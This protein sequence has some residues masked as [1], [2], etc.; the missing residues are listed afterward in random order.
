MS[1]SIDQLKAALIN[2]DAAGD[3]QSAQILADQIAAQQADTYV[4][5]VPKNTYLKDAATG[6]NSGIAEVVDKLADP[7]KSFGAWAGGL[8][9]LGDGT[10]LPNQTENYYP[11]PQTEVGKVAEYVPEV[12]LSVL[13]WEAGASALP[14]MAADTTLGWVG[15]KLAQGAAG[16]VGAS[17]TNLQMPTFE[18]TAEDAL[19]NVALSAVFHIPDAWS[20]AKALINKNQ[21]DVVKAADILGVSPSMGTATGNKAVAT[22]ENLVANLP[23]GAAAIDM[24]RTTERE[25]LNAAVDGIKSDLGFTGSS[26]ELGDE[27]QQGV[28]QYISDFKSES[29]ELYDKLFKA[30][31]SRDKIATPEFGKALQEIADKFKDEPLMAARLDNKFIKDLA[32]AYGEA[33]KIV[34]D[35]EKQDILYS[36]TGNTQNGAISVHSA[37]ALRQTIYDAITDKVSALKDVSSGEL[38]RLYGALTEDLNSHMAQ[39]GGDALKLW[40]EA[41]SHY[42]LGA[43]AIKES[44]G[45]IDAAKTGDAVYTQLFGDASGAMRVPPKQKIASLMQVLPEETQRKIT[46]EVIHRAGLESAG[47][48]GAEGRRFNPATFLTNW[49]KL[50]PEVRDLLFNSD[51]RESLDALATYSGALKNLGKTAN[52]SNTA[53]HVITGVLGGHALVNPLLGIP[54]LAATWA[55][56]RAAAL[57]LTNPKI[58]RKMVDIAAAPTEREV[59]TAMASL[60]ALYINEPSLRGDISNLVHG[61]DN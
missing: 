21:G 41:N 38:S 34:G 20:A 57:I 56:G 43:Q 53:Q 49:N 23:G 6:V 31:Q 10:Y 15:S 2:A 48:A 25:G 47:V 14:E 8:V 35:A 59:N 60:V 52:H 3:T 40:D 45:S 29:N 58:V 11:K 50:S 30:F 26:S 36:L 13:G 51:L 55:G 17:A 28:K 4:K 9:G 12:A 54:Q 16:S 18:N 33:E 27:I 46:A 5:E 1:Y 24:A 7:I 42:A 32:A 44:L 39:L 19:G 37:R 61:D 22:L